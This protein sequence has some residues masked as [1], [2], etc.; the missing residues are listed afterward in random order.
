MVAVPQRVAI[1]RGPGGLPGIDVHIG[2]WLAL[3]AAGIRPTWLSGC[4]AGAI[5]AALDASG[6]PA[7]QAR[8]YVEALRDDDVVKRRFGWK[9]R[10]FWIDHFCDPQPI[11]DLLASLLPAEFRNLRTPLTVSATRMDPV[12]HGVLIRDGDLRAAVLASMSIAGVWPYV[13]VDNAQCTDGGTTHRYPLPPLSL[14]VT[15]GTPPFDAV[16]VLDP[17]S[18]ASFADRDRNMLSRLLWNVEQ[19]GRNQAE[20]LLEALAGNPRVYW[21]PLDMGPGSCLKFDHGLIDA[22]AQRVSKYLNERGFGT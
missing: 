8:E 4:S 1:V 21:L 10:I 9:A 2:A 16:F 18:Y 13:Q 7:W 15:N 14:G 12:A 11:Q 22:T 5:V 6:M 3:E 19:L 17:V 20:W